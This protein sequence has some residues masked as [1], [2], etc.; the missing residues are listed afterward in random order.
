MKKTIAIL[1]A[2]FCLMGC[3]T[4]GIT[5]VSAQEQEEPNYSH[6]FDGLSCDFSFYWRASAGEDVSEANG[7]P[8]EFIM[9]HTRR[10]FGSWYGVSYEAFYEYMTMDPEYGIEEYSVPAD[11]FEAAAA[12]NYNL[13][14]EIVSDLHALEI[15]NTETATYDYV[16]G[17]V[18]GFMHEYSYIGYEKGTKDGTYDIYTYT[19]AIDEPLENVDGLVEGKD[20][21]FIDYYGEDG[22]YC[23]IVGFQKITVSYDGYNAKFLA[24]ET[25]ETVPDELISYYDFF[26]GNTAISEKADASG[27]GWSWTAATKTLALNGVDISVNPVYDNTSADDLDSSK[28]TAYSP[29]AMILPA[30]TTIKVSGENSIKAKIN[31]SVG[32]YMLIAEG[33]ITIEGDGKLTTDGAISIGSEYDGQGYWFENIKNPGTFTVN[34]NVELTVDCSQDIG[35]SSAIWAQNVVINGGKVTAIG[36]VDGICAHR[37]DFNGGEIIAKAF[38]TKEQSE[39]EVGVYASAV[40]SYNEYASE[41]EI[42]EGYINYDGMI[43]KSKT[44]TGYDGEVTVGKA[45]LTLYNDELV[46][47]LLTGETVVTDVRIVADSKPVEVT[48]NDVTVSADEGVFPVGVIINVDPI[49]AESETNKTVLKTLEGQVSKVR[50]Y[51]ITAIMNGAKIQPN[52]KVKVAFKVPSDFDINNIGVFYVSDDGKYEKISFTADKNNRTVTAELSHFSTYVLAELKTADTAVPSGPIPA[53]GDAAN[54][55]LVMLIMS[56]AAALAFALRGK[57]A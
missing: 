56:F 20:Y 17:G 29:V 7:F 19:Y 43:A 5:G 46:P 6:L 24:V 35:Y 40:N 51:D 47:A 25:V 4:L 13:T 31:G 48:K 10:V 16:V 1:L 55:A 32:S 26:V 8:A 44:A 38:I 34:G 27:K 49:A 39:T 3:F 9:E 30:G 21:V 41:D 50:A 14:D 11:V 36:R 42:V 18:G 52:G 37:I 22:Q 53:T 2:I 15:Y 12:Q 54:I 57:K 23:P 28:S 33:P 45:D